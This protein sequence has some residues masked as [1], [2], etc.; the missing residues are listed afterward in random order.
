MHFYC[1]DFSPLD[2]RCD[3]REGRIMARQKPRRLH[4]S[5]R[6]DLVQAFCKISGVTFR[7]LSVYWPCSRV[8]DLHLRHLLISCLSVQIF[9]SLY[10]GN[11]L[12][13]HLILPNALL[14]VDASASADF[15]TTRHDRCSSFSNWRH[16]TGLAKRSEWI[17]VFLGGS[18]GDGGW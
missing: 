7:W 9:P 17:L 12:R 16:N 8:F 6:L 10:S 4:P 15:D 2:L 5:G 18:G 1:A 11:F 3:R 13:F 14:S